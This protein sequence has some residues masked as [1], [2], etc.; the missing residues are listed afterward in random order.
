MYVGKGKTCCIWEG[1]RGARGLHSAMV[2]TYLGRY[3]TGS[4]GTYLG[5]GQSMAGEKVVDVEGA[6]TAGP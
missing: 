3:S 5:W 2:R 1:A 6:S 4:A